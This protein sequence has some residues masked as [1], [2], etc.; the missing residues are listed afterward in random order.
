VRVPTGDL[1]GTS[2]VNDFDAGGQA[3]RA[4]RD[5]GRALTAA[6]AGRL[7]GLPG[8]MPTGVEG[9]SPAAARNSSR[10]SGID[11]AIV[12]TPGTVSAQAMSPQ[13]STPR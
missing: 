2:A 3:A 5:V 6:A 1:D 11:A 12:A 4:Q 13:F 10:A 9:T 7:I 8:A